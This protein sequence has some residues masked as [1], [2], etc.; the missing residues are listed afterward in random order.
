MS[1]SDLIDP[2]IHKPGLKDL[3]G[4]DA[5]IHDGGMQLQIPLNR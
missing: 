2:A 4:E 3:I 1:E 5:Q